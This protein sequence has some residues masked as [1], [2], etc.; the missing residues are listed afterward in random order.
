M[1][2]LPVP[3]PDEAEVRRRLLGRMDLRRLDIGAMAE[4]ELRSLA[5]RCL[6]EVLDEQGLQDGVLRRQIER[7]T[8]QDVVGRGVLEDLLEDDEISEIMING[9]QEI[10]I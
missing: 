1:N 7:R 9:P 10:F 5:A 2:A 6:S 8:L 4:A 3:L